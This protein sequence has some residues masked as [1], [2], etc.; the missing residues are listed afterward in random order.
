MNVKD[1]KVLRY[2]VITDYCYYC[3]Y[4]YYSPGIAQD[5][6]VGWWLRTF[7]SSRLEERGPSPPRGSVS[8]R[9]TEIHPSADV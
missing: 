5:M 8:V 4:C 2:T 1:S 6:A 9:G 3:Y 7:I